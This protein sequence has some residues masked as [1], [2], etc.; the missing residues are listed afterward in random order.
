MFA[1]AAPLGRSFGSSREAGALV[2]AADRG[3]V[4]ARRLGGAECD[5]LAARLDGVKRRVETRR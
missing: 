5:D 2:D 4:E 3:V 1:R